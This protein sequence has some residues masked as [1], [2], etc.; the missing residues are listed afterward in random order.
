MDVANEGVN[1]CI[2]KVKEVESEG[3][4]NNLLEKGY[5]L[6]NVCERKGANESDVIYVFGLTKEQAIEEKK[7]ETGRQEMYEEM[8]ENKK[9]KEDNLQ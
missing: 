2:V 3:L 1:S 6:L 4:A 9:G 7:E 8:I 5:A